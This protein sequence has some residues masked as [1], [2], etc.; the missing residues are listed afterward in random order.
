LW[1]ID[2]KLSSETVVAAPD[3]TVSKRTLEPGL[4]VVATPIGHLSDISTRALE[5]LG[6][7]TEI[8]CED[9]RTSNVLLRHYGIQ[10]KLSALHNFNESQKTESTLKKL[11]AGLS[12]ALVSDAGTPL[13]SDPGYSLVA[14]AR[15]AGFTVRAVP[16]P[17]ALIAALSIC[18]LPCERF[19]FE[20]FL[21]AN[22]KGRRDQMLALSDEPRTLVF[23]EATHRI[24]DM[25]ADVVAIFG[26]DRPI[27]VVKEI[28]KHFENCFTGTAVLVAEKIASDSNL[29]RGEFVVIV[30]GAPAK[31]D[32]EIQARRSFVILCESMPKSQAAKLAAKLTGVSRRLIYA[33]AED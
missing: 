19:C 14:A 12:L 6:A 11:E 7:A 27:S 9:T 10:A 20:G 15:A 1:N 32:A 29:T 23:Y 28:T 18:G 4:Y 17:C 31:S 25:L 21:P 22:S 24:V 16:G 2:M 8:L 26:A 30:Q 5:V 33:G 13:I 3:H